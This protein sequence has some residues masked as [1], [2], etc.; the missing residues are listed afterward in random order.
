VDL[1]DVNQTKGKSAFTF[2]VWVKPDFE[3]TD[4]VT[5]G[6]FYDGMIF[7]IVSQGNLPGFRT[8]LKFPTTVARSNFP[9]LN[10]TPGTWHHM[11]VVYNGSDVRTYWDGV[12]LKTL[13]VTGGLTHTDDIRGKVGVSP[14]LSDYFYGGIDE[15]KIFDHALSASEIASLYSSP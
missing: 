2:S 15:L 8:V 9:G 13:T 3:E 11:A 12:L 4:A 7:G 6:V 14:V 1:G 5:H 10:W